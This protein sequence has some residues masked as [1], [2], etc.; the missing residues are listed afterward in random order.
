MLPATLTAGNQLSYGT[1]TLSTSS[2]AR[3]T[4]ALQSSDTATLTASPYCTVSSGS[5]TNQFVLSSPPPDHWYGPL[6]ITI[7]ATAAGYTA[8]SRTL[9]LTCPDQSR[10]TYHSP[11][12]AHLPQAYTDLVSS[13]GTT[14]AIA[15]W[16]LQDLQLGRAIIAA[17]QAG[18]SVTAVLPPKAPSATIQNQLEDEMIAEGIDLTY[19]QFPKQIQNNVLVIDG[20]TSTVGNYYPS[21]DA[22]QIGQPPNHHR[23]H[24]RRHRRPRNNRS[25]QSL[26]HAR[27]N[28]SEPAVC[29]PVRTWLVLP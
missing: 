10:V 14:I 22:V 29:R 12:S 3:V 4:I 17:A 24:H 19:A 5:L 27:S 11:D 8:G 25:P 9:T 7:S 26:R 2:S 6:K 13:A 28:G 23:R 1:C 18:K 21:P 15:T 16:S 20:T